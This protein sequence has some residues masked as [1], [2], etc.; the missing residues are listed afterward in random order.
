M[1]SLFS[2]LSFF[3]KS[4]CFR[5]NFEIRKREFKEFSCLNEDISH[6]FIKEKRENPKYFMMAPSWLQEDLEGVYYDQ[7]SFNTKATAKKMFTCL[8]RSFSS[9]TPSVFFFLALYILD[10]DVYNLSSSIVDLEKAQR[11]VH[12]IFCRI[13][14][15]TDSHELETFEE[16]YKKCLERPVFAN[17]DFPCISLCFSSTLNVLENMFNDQVSERTATGES[18][19]NLINLKNL[20]EIISSDNFLAREIDD[21]PLLHLLLTY[22]G[23]KKNIILVEKMTGRKPLFFLECL[24]IQEY[25]EK[26]LMTIAV[27]IECLKESLTKI[28]S[29]E[30][31][32]KE[33]FEFE[34]S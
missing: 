11:E 7:D 2:L 34:S 14:D 3:D 30:E 13:F 8:A 25:T 24:D 31:E 1:L 6:L 33:N 26:I 32:P 4:L 9:L 21:S 22:W 27:H 19:V 16:I 20:K 5:L 28:H 12:N 17:Y 29:N 18:G 10:Y 23:L 15:D